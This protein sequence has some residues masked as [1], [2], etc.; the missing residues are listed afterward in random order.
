VSGSSH[1]SY[2]A[3]SGPWARRRLRWS[4]ISSTPKP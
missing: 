1:A 4:E 2:G 3:H